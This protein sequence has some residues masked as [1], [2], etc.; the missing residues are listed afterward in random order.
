MKKPYK[1]KKTKSLY[2]FILVTAIPI[3]GII[4]V[5]WLSYMQLKKDIVFVSHELKGISIISQI[6]KSV[7]NIQKL[8]G[9]VC[10]DTPN[11]ESLHNIESLKK[12]I[13]RQMDGL[14]NALATIDDDDTY[15]KKEALEFVDH[16]RATDIQNYDFKEFTQLIETFLSL[17]KRVSYHCKL[18]LE[19][20]IKSFLLARNI[21]FLLPQLI[22]FNG[23]IRATTTSAKE[24][25]LNE[26]QKQYLFM[27]LNKIEDKLKEVDFNQQLLRT[28]IDKYEKL[29]TAYTNMKDAQ[30]KITDFTTRNI[31]YHGDTGFDPNGIFKEISNN[32]EAVIE[33]YEFNLNL[34]G[35]NLRQKLK[36][37]TLYQIYSIIFAFSC[38]LFVTLLNRMFYIKNREYIAKI[39]ELTI[40]DSMTGLYNRRYFDE[41]FEH[42]LR[43]QQRAAQPLS[44]IIFDIDF[45][46]QYNDTYG[47]QAGDE[48]LKRV[49][50]CVK[51][52][53]QRSTDMAFRL[54]GEE[55][56]ILCLGMSEQETFSFA[57]HIRQKIQ[58]LGI[59]HKKSDISRYISV[60]MG[61]IVIKE[62]RIDTAAHIYRHAD[63]ALYRA[64]ERGRNC[65][66][67]YECS[68]KE[69]F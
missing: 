51:E 13:L 33:M 28:K 46:K 50:K 45:F 44:L 61:V 5:F 20:D 6:Q 49:S 29:R 8:R 63:E 22:E 16:V 66:V 25:A 26:Y 62:C 7:F 9:L 14:Y 10:I 56:G 11:D 27:L 54:G 18:I 39:E 4:I 58:D 21:V 52:S 55:F 24:G 35:T 30:Q 40:T 64:K 42:N 47:H 53:L 1:D 23:Q 59:E 34:L 12:E 2:F 48:A 19:A 69:I 37:S 57:E 67:L 31:V 17:S 68:P 60:S 38:I 36:N 15:L 32:I 3:I 65:A 43:M 41:M